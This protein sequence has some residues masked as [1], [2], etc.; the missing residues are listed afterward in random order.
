MFIPAGFV[1][2]I[3]VRWDAFQMQTPQQKL[4]KNTL[5][6]QARRGVFIGLMMLLGQCAWGLLEAAPLTPVTAD[7]GRQTTTDAT[8]LLPRARQ[9]LEDGDTAAALTASGDTR[10]SESIAQ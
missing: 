6:Q 2:M 1:T 5:P 8:T 4:R 9:L 3:P 7:S 10:L